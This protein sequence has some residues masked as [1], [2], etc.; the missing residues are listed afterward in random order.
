MNERIARE[1]RLEL[2]VNGKITKTFNYTPGLEEELV[3]GYLISSATITEPNQINAMEL[4]NSTCTLSLANTKAEVDLRNE[5]ES[6]IVHF[7]DLQF[8]R[9]MLFENQHHHKSTRGFHGAIIY[10]P[11]TGKHFHCEDIGRHNTVDKV[12]GLVFRNDYSLLDCII[13]TTGRLTCSIVSKCVNAGVPVL[14]SMT[15]ATDKGIAIAKN[16]NLT[17]I[18]SLTD[19]EC[20]LYHEGDV[21]INLN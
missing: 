18:G 5:H 1:S 7:T 11:N 14:V 19:T 6:M 4:T 20:W 8:M 17:L 15:V 13:M 10:Q 9:K 12:I 21:K 2:V 16:S 3:L